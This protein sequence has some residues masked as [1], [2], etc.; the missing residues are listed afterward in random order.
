V[1]AELPPNAAAPGRFWSL[2]GAARLHY[3]SFCNLSVSLCGL[4]TVALERAGGDGGGER[5]SG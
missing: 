5:V 2:S 1:E 3:G 4:R